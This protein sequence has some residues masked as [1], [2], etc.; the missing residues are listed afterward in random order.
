M[1]V[2]IKLPSIVLDWRKQ[3]QTNWSSQEPDYTCKV[4]RNNHDWHWRAKL[5]VFGQEAETWP[6]CWQDQHWR[7]DARLL[8]MEGLRPRGTGARLTGGGREKGGAGKGER[9]TGGKYIGS[10]IQGKKRGLREEPYAREWAS[11]L[12]EGSGTTVEKGRGNGFYSKSCSWGSGNGY[13]SDLSWVSKLLPLPF[14]SQQGTS[15]LE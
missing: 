15:L 11:E 3:N 4:A 9:L 13:S 6:N 2:K 12:A 5:A 10:G 7:F 14:S 8:V 1:R